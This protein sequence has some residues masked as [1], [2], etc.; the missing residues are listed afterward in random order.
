[1]K[2]HTLRP[3]RWRTNYP[4]PNSDKG[5]EVPI[6]ELSPSFKHGMEAVLDETTLPPHIQSAIAGMQH[7]DTLT[8]DGRTYRRFH[9]L[10]RLLPLAKR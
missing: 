9:P 6:V 5:D 2:V 3:A 8:I 4:R 1:M 7:G 10:K